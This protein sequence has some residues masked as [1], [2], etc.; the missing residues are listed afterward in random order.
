MQYVG[1]ISGVGK[2]SLSRFFQQAAFDR[3]GIGVKYEHWPTPA[4][5]LETRVI[6]LRA[7]S[8]LGANVTI[9]HKQACVGMMDSVDPLV[10]K[11]GA[12]N[13]ILNDEGKLRGYNTDV[14]GFLTA[15]AD[16]YFEPRG[17][18]ALIAGAGGAAR[19]V[20]V[21]LA[22]RGAARIVVIN[23]TPE[24]AERLVAELTPIVGDTELVARPDTRESWEDATA[25]AGLLVNCTSLGSAGTPEEDQ[26][27]VPADLIHSQAL[28]YD[29]VYGP[30]ATKLIR[31]ARAAGARTV[32]GLP[33]LIHQGAAS[34]ELWTG[35]KAPLDVMFQAAEEALAEESG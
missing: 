8:V 1:V 10:E 20:V 25:E 32:G 3:L 13:T 16:A 18:R 19:A 23:R 5:G 11:V 2:K 35:Q 6:G 30:A 12:L 33:M 21:G 17:C 34:F 26:S 28:V 7:P 4:D 9:P 27:P 29:L 31:D 15:L 22:G 24:R 14:H